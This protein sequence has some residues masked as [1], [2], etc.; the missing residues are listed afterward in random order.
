MK[1]VEWDNPSWIWAVPFDAI[2][3]AHRKNSGDVGFNEEFRGEI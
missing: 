1:T 3:G 2:L